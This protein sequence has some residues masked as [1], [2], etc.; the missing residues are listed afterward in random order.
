M[1]GFLPNYSVDNFFKVKKPLL[2]AI[3]AEFSMRAK[4]AR[5]IA[6]KVFIEGK[7]LVVLPK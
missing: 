3:M 2:L 5:L 1:N 4:I 6:S 7:T